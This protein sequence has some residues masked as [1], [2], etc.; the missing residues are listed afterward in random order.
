MNKEDLL[1]AKSAFDVKMLECIFRSHGAISKSQL[2]NN[3]Q[4]TSRMVSDHVITLNDSLK[5]LRNV[6]FVQLTETRTMIVLEI[7]PDSSLE[8]I[9]NHIIQESLV[10]KILAYA[11]WHPN[12]T[13]QKMQQALLISESTLFRAMNKVNHLLSEFQISIRNNRINGREINIRH[14]YYNLFST[15]NAT[16]PKLATVAEPHIQQFITDFE[17]LIGSRLSEIG[18]NAINIFYNINLQRNKS[19]HLD[20]ALDIVNLKA[21]AEKPYGRKL[22]QIFHKNL[23]IVFRDLDF[24]VVNFILFISSERILSWDSEF[25]KFIHNTGALSAHLDRIRSVVAEIVD[26]ISVKFHFS[27]HFNF[28]RYTLYYEIGNIILF[29]G[30]FSSF[31]QLL[32]TIDQTNHWTE[33]SGQNQFCGCLITKLQKIDPIFQSPEI[34]LFLKGY[35]TLILRLLVGQT[36]KTFQIGFYDMHEQSINYYL[37][38]KLM[39]LISAHF[40]VALTPFKATQKYDLVLTTTNM[41]NRQTLLDTVQT[42]QRIIEIKDFGAQEDISRVMIAL[43]HCVSA[44]LKMDLDVYL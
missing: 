4:T 27:Q 43:D 40:N 31:H 11:F 44:Y 33:D 29:P 37:Q 19:R 30:I 15:L 13:M 42:N 3:L 6:N 9:T 8:E 20:T 41:Y 26:F 14:F 17:H 16:N 25:F 10:Y 38:S 39:T 21:M 28:L 18:R 34:V 1:D 32:D 35:F 23:R 7:S 24:E 5:M 22:I 12:F 2:I 36:T